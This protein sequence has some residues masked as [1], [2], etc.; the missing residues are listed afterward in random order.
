MKATT[1]TDSSR[2]R[3]DTLIEVLIA[4]V[5]IA[6]AVTAIVGALVAGIGASGEHRN[7]AVN[8]TLLKSQADSLKR[9]IELGANPQFKPCAQPSDYQGMVS[10][11]PTGYTVDVKTVEYWSGTTFT[12][13]CPP[14]SD[15]RDQQLQLV[16]ITAATSDGAASQ[17]LS[18]VVRDPS[19]ASTTTTG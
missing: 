7:L 2:E 8:D 16:Q 10:Q 4:I 11:P 15:P 18:I 13:T 12:T 14:Q 1:T 9:Q 17:E 3:G 5:V 6:L 19:Y